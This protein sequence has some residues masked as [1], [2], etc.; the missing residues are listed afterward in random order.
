MACNGILEAILL[1]RKILRQAVV[2]LEITYERETCIGDERNRPI[3]LTTKGDII[4]YSQLIECRN[5]E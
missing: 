5:T 3:Y 1:A 4:I 2:V